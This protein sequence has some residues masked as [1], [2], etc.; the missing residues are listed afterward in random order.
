MVMYI[1]ELGRGGAYLDSQVRR[2]TALYDTQ[3]FLEY[4]HMTSSKCF[5]NYLDMSPVA[6]IITCIT[7]VPHTRFSYVQGPRILR[8][9][10]FPPPS[11]G[12]ATFIARY[13]P[14]LTRTTSLR[15]C[16]S[17]VLTNRLMKWTRL[18]LWTP[19]TFRHIHSTFK[20]KQKPHYESP[21]EN[22]LLC[23]VVS[24]DSFRLPISYKFH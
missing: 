20:R 24:V 21:S 2:R 19:H 18:H 3:F 1:Y 14:L 16:S 12:M 6:F 4:V 17:L 8:K 15:F 7:C 13:F 11:Y 9:F 5:A 22:C 10:P 23:T